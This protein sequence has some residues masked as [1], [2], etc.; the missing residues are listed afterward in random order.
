M[1]RNILILTMLLA[2]A[3]CGHAQSKYSN[4]FLSLGLGARGLG[5][6]HL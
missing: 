6:H 1:K 4:E 3:V 5:N 2:I